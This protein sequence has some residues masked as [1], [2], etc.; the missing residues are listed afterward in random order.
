MK[1]LQFTSI[2]PSI[3]RWENSISLF[4]TLYLEITILEKYIRI[5]LIFIIKFFF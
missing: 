1:L 3:Y 2:F 5:Y 4:F